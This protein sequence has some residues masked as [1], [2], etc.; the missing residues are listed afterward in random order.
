MTYVGRSIYNDP[1][2]I[3]HHGIKEQKWGRRRF[4][5]PDGSLTYA[6]KLRYR[7]LQKKQA[8]F[9]KRANKFSNKMEDLI[10][11]KEE[12]PPKKSISQMSNDEIRKEI[13]RMD[14][15]KKYKQ[16]L[17]ESKASESNFKNNGQKFYNSIVKPALV[18]VGKQAAENAI[19]MSAN[20]LGKM[21]G[22]TN[23]MYSVKTSKYSSRDKD[24]ERT[25]ES[26]KLKSELEKERLKLEQ[27]KVR[28]EQER[29]RRQGNQNR[30]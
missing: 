18:N 8:K 30:S 21:L 15:E 19:G 14:L 17:S 6:G 16:Y 1:N 9:E 25:Y 24:A 4:Q 3:T 10:P 23:E 7:K 2:F 5:N 27:E 20:K 11:K 12:G 29:L 22:F 26:N 13:E 28:L